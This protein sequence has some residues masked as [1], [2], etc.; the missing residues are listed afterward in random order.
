MSSGNSARRRHLSLWRA[1]DPRRSAAA[2]CMLPLPERK[3]CPKTPI[4]MPVH[5]H[6]VRE[7]RRA[8]FL[9]LP[10]APRTRGDCAAAGT[11]HAAVDTALLT[12]CGAQ[13]HPAACGSTRTSTTCREANRGHLC[14]ARSVRPGRRAP[15]DSAGGGRGCARAQQHAPRAMRSDRVSRVAGAARPRAHQLQRSSKG[16]AAVRHAAGVRRARLLLLRR[17]AAQLPSPRHRHHRPNYTLPRAAAPVRFLRCP[18]T[19]GREQA[20]HEF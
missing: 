8:D 7:A 9:C 5:V 16:R 18:A 19:S 14:E 12:T 1:A 2:R 13:F 3:M 6:A 20:F 10:A 11:K 4:A 15:G 17:L